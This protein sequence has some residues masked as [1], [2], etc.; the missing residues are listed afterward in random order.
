MSLRIFS[1]LSQNLLSQKKKNSKRNG[2]IWCKVEVVWREEAEKNRTKCI[3][4]HMLNLP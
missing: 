3:V 2:R 1:V 4:Y